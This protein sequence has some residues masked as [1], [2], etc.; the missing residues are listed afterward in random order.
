MH[1]PYQEG[2]FLLLKAIDWPIVGMV[3][4]RNTQR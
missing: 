2:L 1:F 4:Q 3:L